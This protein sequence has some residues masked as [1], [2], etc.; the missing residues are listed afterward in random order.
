MKKIYLLICVFFICCCTPATKKNCE[1]CI[2]I[3]FSEIKQKESN[4]ETFILILKSD[5]CSVCQNY[6]Y[7]LDNYLENN[8]IKIY[9]LDSKT[10][11]MNDQKVKYFIENVKQIAGVSDNYI[12]PSTI[13]FL[14][15]KIIN[16]EIGVLSEKELAK[17]VELLFSLK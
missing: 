11:D 17:N 15:G 1:N 8:N 3:T 2:N 10:I 7:V 9:T 6:N 4:Y 13:F 12:L 14:D 16:V 5:E